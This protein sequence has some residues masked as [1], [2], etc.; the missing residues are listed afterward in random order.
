MAKHNFGPVNHSIS[1]DTEFIK[2]NNQVMN[3]IDKYAPLKKK[4][5]K[6]T[7]WMTREIVDSMKIR[8]KS[9]KKA[10]LSRNK[11]DW[12]IY[13]RERNE[14]TRKTNQGKRT[15]FKDKFQKSTEST[16]L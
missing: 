8:N 4:L 14:T 15:Y 16:S 7:P 10:L 12:L 13:R 6:G 3:I 9:H 1:V 5:V 11:E 2:Y